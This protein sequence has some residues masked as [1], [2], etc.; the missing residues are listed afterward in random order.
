MTTQ[1]SRRDFVGGASL[2]AL[3]VATGAAAKTVRADEAVEGIAVNLPQEWDEETDVVVIGTGTTMYGAIKMASEGLDVIAIDAFMT[4]GGTAALSGGHQWLPCNPIAVENGDTREAA[5]AYIRHCASEVEVSDELV[6]A[7]IDNTTPMLEFIDPIL[8]DTS[9]NVGYVLTAGFGDYHPDWD[10]G[11][12]QGR[13]VDF[14][15]GKSGDAACD[16]TIWSAAVMEAAEKLGVDI[17]TNTRATDL[18][19][20]IQSNGVPQV[21]GVVVEDGEGTKA[22][23][24]R[25]AVLM[26]CGGFEWNE[27]YKKRFLRVPSVYPTTLST[28]DGFGVRMGMK[29]GA[30]L[31]NMTACFGNMT[32]RESA[33]ERTAMGAPAG[34]VFSRHRP[35]TM[36]VN[37]DG[38]RFFDEA[39]DTHAACKSFANMDPTGE[40][41]DAAMPAWFVADSRWLAAGGP[42]DYLMG[43]VDERGVYPFFK[44][45]DTLEELAALMD[46]DDETTQT[47]LNE[48]EVFNGYCDDLYDP[49]FK[50]GTNL[51]DVINA[52]GDPNAEGPARTL[53]AVA[54]PPFYAAQMAPSTLGTCGGPAINVR[55][56]VMH[57]TGEPISGLYACGNC[58]GFGG[59]GYNY[60]GNGGALGPGFTMGYIAACSIIEEAR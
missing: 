16:K 19:Y 39:C 45:A 60:G 38:R 4:P 2:A 23:K 32:Y 51:Y 43:D 26:G 11:L 12:Q 40:C 49:Q 58:T 50:R 57:A 59:P 36:I 21:L 25:N 10:G 9:Q 53:G 46:F 24:A 41:G 30:D 55:A 3:G 6:Y 14:R 35:H 37:K 17:R 7:F 22:I 13:T 48:V 44:M 42:T 15:V 5:Y 31:K 1:V 56:Q 27:D 33:D 52:E 18:V 54:E 8:Q 20:S 47:F 28:N 34:I 29:L